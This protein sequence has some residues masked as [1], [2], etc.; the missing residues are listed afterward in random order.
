MKNISMGLGFMASLASFKGQIL[1]IFRNGYNRYVK[2]Q[3]RAKNAKN[4]QKGAAKPMNKKKRVYVAGK[5]NDMSCDYIKN[6]SEMIRFANEIREL[7][8]AVFVPGLDILAGLVS[9]KMTYKDYFNNNVEWLKVSDAM[10]VVPGSDKSRGTQE[11]IVIALHLGI[12]V[13][14]NLEELR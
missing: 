9:G 11:E 14:Y 10:F 4:W 1:D 6:L 8:H 7:G 5:L 13:I 3:K 2:C 12:P